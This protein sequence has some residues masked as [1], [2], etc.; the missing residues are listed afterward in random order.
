VSGAPDARESLASGAAPQAD[1]SSGDVL[2][3]DAAGGL[4]IRGGV[5]RLAS[6]V[7]I[8]LLSLIPAVLLTR[9][10][11]AITF[12]KYTTVISLVTVVALV[13]DTGMSNLGIREYAVLV[14]DERDAVMR[15]LLGLRVV[16]TLG[17]VLLATLFAILAGYSPA[18]L[19]GTIA[20]SLAT[21]ALVLQHTLSIPLASELRI[22]VMSAIEVARQALTVVGIVALIAVG[23]GVFP[24]LAVMLVVYLLLVPVTGAFVRGRISLRMGLRPSHWVALLRPTVSYSLA[25]AVGAIYVYTAQII[26]SLATTPHQNGLF[27][28][29]FRIFIITVAAPGLLVSGAVP[30]LARAARDDRERLAYA[31]QRIFEV[32][33]ILGIATAIGMFAA[34]PLIVKVLAGPKLPEYHGSIEVLRILGLAMIASFLI[35]GWGFAL[36]SIKSYRALL[37]I[38]GAALLVSCVLTPILASTY[39]ATGAA[40]AVLGG[41]STLAVG[42]VVALT[43]R[44]RELRPHLAIV[45]RIL[46]AAA[47]ATALVLALD[48]SSA[49]LTVIALLV[50]GL[51]IVLTRAMPSEIVELI[52][53]RRPR[54]QPVR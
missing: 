38:N 51:L 41:E 7:T 25:T 12:G 24:L 13:T 46:I 44:H 14:G 5:L 18:L 32:S 17:G 23:G 53:R 22:G 4:I 31:L 47:P 39:G 11:G 6:Y 19:A 49:L 54:E 16:L 2:D 37:L 42:Y 34:A 43:R 28:L 10:L 45:P 48:L 3:T 8:V 26:T 50:Y 15:N 29:S 35:A 21:V 30:L 40:F 27:A 36:L 20:A 33:L 1:G 9:Y 52:P